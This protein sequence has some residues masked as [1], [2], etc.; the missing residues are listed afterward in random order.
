MKA[1]L[2]RKFGPINSHKIEEIDNLVPGDNEVVVN[3]HS[4][5]VAFPDVL[6][7]Q[8]LY[9]MTPD[10]PFS[11]GGEFT[12]II[13]EVGKNVTKCKLNDRVIGFKGSGGFAEEALCHE[14]NIMP[15]PDS[16]DY[17]TGS[18]FP[19]N[20]G[21]SIHAFKQRAEL[22]KGDNVLIMGAAGGLGIAAIH[23]AKAMG[24]NVIAAASSNE[25]LDLCKQ[26]GADSTVLYSRDNMDRDSQKNFSSELKA[27]TN[28]K[29]V[30][31]VFDPVGGAYSEPALRAIAWKGRYL[32]IGFTSSIP[33]IPLNLALLKGCQII[34][35]FWGA[36]CMREPNINNENFHQ[37]FLMYEKGQIKPFVT[38]TFPLEQTAEAINKLANRNAIGKI[39]ISVID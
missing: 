13:S 14:S 3:V 33:S 16:M 31:V 17:Q 39:T 20:Y 15:L 35:V 5:G 22:K 4:A 10:F 18:I 27:L 32:V 25:K 19:L 26:Q 30:D 1:Y 23:V 11:P 21:T 7:V 36:F 28:N 8:G 9:Q 2:C 24:A 37:L 29:G 38:E 34:G 12:G 6:V